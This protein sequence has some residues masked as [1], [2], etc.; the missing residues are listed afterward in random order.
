MKVCSVTCSILHKVYNLGETPY[1]ILEYCTYGKLNEY[2][3]SCQ[4]A[5][6]QLG[7][8][9]QSVNLQ[10]AS[11]FVRKSSNSTD[12]V[13]I[14]LS[15]SSSS[16]YLN[17]HQV[18]TRNNSLLSEQSDSVFSDNVAY[19]PESVDSYQK[20]YTPA[21]DI[22]SL[23]RDYASSPGLLVNEDIVNFALQIAYGLQHLEK[24]NV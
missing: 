2:L 7:L 3:R 12:Y 9:I 6:V 21:S 1:I 4:E 20:P 24:L 8:P 19:M 18:L 5:L 16:T 13:N 10:D 11:N 14:L 23:S 17:L 15:N 22:V